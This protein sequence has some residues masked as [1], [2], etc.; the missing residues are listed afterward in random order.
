MARLYGSKWQRAREI[1]LSANPLCV[2]HARRG[3]LPVE[4]TVVDHIVA[5]K[6][7]LKLFWDRKNWQALCKHCHDSHKQR[8]E[9][10]GGAV[11]CSLSGVPLD[12]NH[13]WNK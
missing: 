10:S 7:D 1:F 8:E 6:G 5:H 3:S 2:F 12:A 11:G 13:H 9:K 4:A